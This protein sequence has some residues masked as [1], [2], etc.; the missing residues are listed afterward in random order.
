MEGIILP[1]QPQQRGR[2]LCLPRLPTRIRWAFWFRQTPRRP[3]SAAFPR[4]A[5]GVGEHDAEMRCLQSSKGHLSARGSS[6]HGMT[7][8]SGRAR[9]LRAANP[10]HRA[11]S[12]W[13]MGCSSGG[14]SMAKLARVVVPGVPHNIVRKPSAG[15]VL[16]REFHAHE[17]TGRPLS[18]QDCMPRL[19]RELGRVRQ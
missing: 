5:D 16:L 7:Q 14:L 13:H 12:Q 18:D 10:E 19:E 3:R 17:R 6:I 1:S 4:R 9:G 8:V 2:R 15:D 11:Y